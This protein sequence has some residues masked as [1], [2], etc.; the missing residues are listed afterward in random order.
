MKI[1]LIEN[2]GYETILL[3]NKL[4]KEGF[5]CDICNCGCIGLSTSINKSYDLILMNT[6]LPKLNAEEICKALRQSKVSTPIIVL[7]NKKD[8]NTK[9]NHFYSGCDDFVIKPYEEKELISRIL[10]VLRRPKPFRDNVI[11]FE[12]I[13]IDTFKKIV[14]I[15]DKIVN[16]TNKEFLLL[17]LLMKNIGRVIPRDEIFYS[18][19]DENSNAFNNIVEV[20]INKLRKK[21]YTLSNSKI[22]KNTKGLGYYIGK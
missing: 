1:L 13:K 22:I 10:A 3:K 14:Q 19:W 16:L 20:Y 17:K 21:L 12:N 6:S 2:E 8:I 9:I 4:I 18:I 5:S 7:S 11:E 15:N